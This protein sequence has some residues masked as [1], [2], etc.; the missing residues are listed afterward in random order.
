MDRACV[1]GL[2]RALGLRCTGYHCGG[3]VR[4]AL[5]CLRCDRGIEQ[6]STARYCLDQAVVVITELAAQL[7]NAL[8]DGVIRNDDIGPDRV[9]KL[10]LGDE[11]SGVLREVL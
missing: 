10:L 2:R 7:A 1:C 6:I 4:Q 11:A 3:S 8:R 9:I 5:R